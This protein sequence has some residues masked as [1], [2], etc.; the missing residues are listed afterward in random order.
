[1]GTIQAASKLPNAL[2]ILSS[3]FAISASL[4]ATYAYVNPPVAL[5]VGWWLGNES[6][7][8]NVL[9]GLPVVLGAVA[10][11]AWLQTRDTPQVPA[12]VS[13]GTAPILPSQARSKP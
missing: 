5:A 13:R 9:V 7:S 1:M 11:H 3:A 8:A 10:L 6:F 12:S 4:A 2:L